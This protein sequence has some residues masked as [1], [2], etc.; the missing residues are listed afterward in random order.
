[1]INFGMKSINFFSKYEASVPERGK[2]SYLYLQL[3]IVF[4]NV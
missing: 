4:K 3:A 1:M 2:E